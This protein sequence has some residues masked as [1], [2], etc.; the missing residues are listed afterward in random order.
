VIDRAA[1]L[2]DFIDAVIDMRDLQKRFFSSRSADRAA[3]E[4]CVV[5]A[6]AAERKVDAMVR[7][8]RPARVP[9]QELEL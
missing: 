7:Q 9:Q 6:K 8:L 2:D 3:R 1:Q 4:A 5:A